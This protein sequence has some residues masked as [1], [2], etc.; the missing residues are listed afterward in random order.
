MVSDRMDVSWAWLMGQ[1]IGMKR[2]LAERDGTIATLSSEKAELS[3]ALTDLRGVV[4]VLRGEM[5]R[6]R[7][8]IEDLKRRGK[9][10]AAPFSKE[11]R[12]LLPKRSGRKKGEGAFTY[13]AAPPVEARTEEPVDVG[14]GVCQRC[15]GAVEAEGVEVCTVTDLPKVV[16]P[17][18]TEYRVS[19]GRCCGCGTKVRGSHPD[20]AWDQR[21]ATA[22]RLGPRVKA[23]GLWLHYGVGV[24]LRKVPEVIREW[25]GITLTQSALTQAA[26]S[27]SDPAGKMEAAYQA[28]RQGIATS[29][30]VNTDDTGW[31]IG[32]KTAFLMGFETDEAVLFPERERHRNE[33][34][35][36]VIPANYKGTMGCDRGK[37]YDA[38]EL[39]AVAQQKCLSHIQRNLADL[40][41][42]KEGVG[43]EWASDLKSLFGS[44]MG[45]WRDHR[46]GGI[47]DE[48]YRLD[49]EPLKAAITQ[50]LSDRDLDDP[51][52]SRLLRELGR[53]H[54]K[55]D[56]LR[57][58]ADPRI[59]P[60][61]N[62]AERAL[63]PAVI[64]RKVSHCSKNARGAQAFAAFVSVIRTEIKT[65]HG[66]IVA[67][68]ATFLDTTASSPTPPTS[69]DT[70]HSPISTLSLAPSASP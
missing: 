18:V 70:P 35:R 11:Q 55:G 13:R 51:D 66:S 56:L 69:H 4:A 68:L 7:R 32:G 61:N 25:S 6:Q 59:E 43:R 64:A 52:A 47:D 45:L 36:E 39:E 14:L 30:R 10:Q 57:F 2:A 20:L 50:A 1:M 19:V 22:H 21:G 24:P 17:L 9:R 31:K 53:H 49:G 29:E 8:E 37:S 28:L 60:T 3:E 44:T 58:L 42:T 27:Q 54:A 33:E 62:R 23:M 5:E 48:R 12:V 26:L 41:E 38:K 34:V 16:R 65:G 63:R 40:V 15:G 46:A 67:R